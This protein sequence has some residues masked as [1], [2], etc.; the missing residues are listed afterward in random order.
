[1]RLADGR[2]TFIDFR[3]KAPAKATHDMYLDAAGQLTEDSIVGWRS[4]GVPGTARGLELAHKKYGQRPWAE[5]LKPAIKLAADGFP[6]SHAQMES[7][8]Y[9]SSLLSQFPDSKRIFLNNG[10]NYD[11][12]QTFKQPELAH[13]LARIAR[14]GAADFYEGETAHV[15]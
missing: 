14:L 9:Y 6:V 3:E 15:L 8:K 1:V 2:T 13:T 4:V 11:W 7:W 5:L 10:A 12:Q